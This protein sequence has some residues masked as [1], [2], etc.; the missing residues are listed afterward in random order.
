[1]TDHIQSWTEQIRGGNLRALARAITAV[2]DR[3]PES[4]EL[5]KMFFLFS[6]KA[7]ILGL[8]GAPGAGKSTLVDALAREYRRRDKTVGIIAV[9]PTAHLPVGQFS[10]TESACKR[11]M[12]IPAFTSAAWQLAVH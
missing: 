2:E 7:R 9:D 12:P 3:T 5:L 6:G 8:T 4:H 1:M 10:A 11:I